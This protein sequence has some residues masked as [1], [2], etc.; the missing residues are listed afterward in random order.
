M[1]STPR[2]TVEPALDGTRIM[3]PRP[4]RTNPGKGLFGIGLMVAIWSLIALVVLQDTPWQPWANYLLPPILGVA[5]GV[6]ILGLVV[7]AIRTPDPTHYEIV[8][9]PKGVT[10]DGEQMNHDVRM[11]L[12]DEKLVFRDTDRQVEVWHGI[13]DLDERMRMR[14]LLEQALDASQARHG[15]GEAHVPEALRNRQLE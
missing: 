6:A 15:Q 1:S 10:V 11:V 5:T 8:L 13:R 9:S 4:G 3:A 14:E 7:M 2:F 12:H